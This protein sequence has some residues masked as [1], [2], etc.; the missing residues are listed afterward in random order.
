MSDVSSGV[1]E[2][3]YSNDSITWTSWEPAS[4]SKPWVLTGGDGNSKIVY[5][6]IKDNAGLI[7]RF[8]DTIGLDTMAPIIIINSPFNNSYWNLQPLINITALDLNLDDIWY[9]VGSDQRIIANNTEEALDIDIWN[10]LDNGQFELNIW[11][12]DNFNQISETKILTLY[13]DTQAPQIDINLP[14]NE[15]YWNT[16][17]EILISAFDPN[18]ES[19]WYE[20]NG[21]KVMLTNGVSESLDSSIWNG[22]SQGAFQ[23]YIYSNDTF[24][25]LN[26][27]NIITLFK[28]T[29]TPSIEINSPINDTFWSSPSGYSSICN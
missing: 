9:R 7:T 24:G 23:I 1:Q 6:E 17:P 8:S 4:A 16:E 10:S 27:S 20:V 28:D 19:I 29:I 14:G 3:R 5:Y 15:T 18:F 26:N 12:V 21:I 25:H 11:A 13:K 22:L 2:V